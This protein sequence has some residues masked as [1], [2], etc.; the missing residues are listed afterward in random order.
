MAPWPDTEAALAKVLPD[1]RLYL[2]GDGLRPYV[3]WVEGSTMRLA[4]VDPAGLPLPPLVREL[5]GG[6]Y[7]LAGFRRETEDPRG[8]VANVAL[9]EPLARRLDVPKVLLIGLGDAERYRG[10]RLPL[11]VARLSQWLRFT[12]S[13]HVTVIDYNFVD[14]PLQAVA[15]RLGGEHFDI[16]GVSVNFGQWQMLEE[17]AVVVNKHQPSLVVLGNILAAFSPDRAAELFDAT[18][19][20]A[21]F[22]ATSLGERPLETLCREYRHP[23]SWDAIDGLIRPLKPAPAPAL[24]RRIELPELVYPDDSL[25]LTVAERGGQIALETSFGCQY[26]ACTFCPRDHRGDGWERGHHSTAVAILERVAASGAVVSLVDEEFFGSEGLVD[27]PMAELPAATVLAACRRLEISYEIYT[28]L[29]QLFDRRKSR[30]WNIERARLLATE[31]P[32]MRRIFVGVESGSPSQLR[33]YGKG[34]TVKQTVDALRI[35]SA[36]GTPME[37]G[38]ITFDP[39]V[40]PLELAE[41]LRFLARRD[42]IAVRGQGTLDDQVQQVTRYLD[43]GDLPSSGIP[44]YRYVSYMATELEVLA[45]SRYADHLRRLHPDLLDGAY[46]SSFA[47]H[48]VRY[49]DGRIE[50]IAGWCRVWTEGMF[51]PVYEARMT[52]RASG[53]PADAVAAAELV[54]RYRDA[55]FSLLVG[56]T[57][58]RLP[59]FSDE[60][61]SLPTSYELSA[62]KDTGEWLDELVAE[63]LPGSPPVHF[64]MQLRGRRRDR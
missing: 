16:V 14:A 41:N 37:F 5:L 42:V 48:G 64:D 2:G 63:T 11:G 1:A 47:R 58:T 24:L 28:R 22:V 29:E 57:R 21:V 7:G 17:L 35:G 46:D 60:F 3:S 23:E 49:R 8:Y 54:T 20:D 9:S 56:L 27:P 19:D 12:H 33:R 51:T 36:L 53:K 62:G 38:F 34:Q 15:D 10:A 52:A 25:V 39:L 13:A 4:G 18:R 43:G 55:T 31:A 40:T 61:T 30:A 6:G 50:D 32:S 45:H 26:G 59:E 44:L